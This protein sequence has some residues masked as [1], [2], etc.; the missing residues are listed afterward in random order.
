[1]EPNTRNLIPLDNFELSFS[2]YIS[3]I[4]QWRRLKKWQSR[5]IIRVETEAPLC[6]IQIVNTNIFIS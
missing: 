1:M 4:S 3:R 5:R 6:E 2:L